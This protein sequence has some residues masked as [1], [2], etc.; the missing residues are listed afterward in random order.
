M[1][2]AAR[3]R[4]RAAGGEV[5]ALTRSRPPQ[6]PELMQ[7]RTDMEHARAAMELSE[8]FKA[9]IA[10]APRLGPDQ[11]AALREILSES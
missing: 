9:L 7:A 2:S 3:T 11:R 5:A 10:A 4:S 8:H 6:D 1:E